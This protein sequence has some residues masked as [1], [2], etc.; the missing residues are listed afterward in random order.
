MARRG[1]Q[2]ANPLD[3]RMATDDAIQFGFVEAPDA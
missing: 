1:Y 3:E 2:H